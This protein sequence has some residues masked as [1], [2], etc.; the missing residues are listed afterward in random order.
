MVCGEDTMA[1]KKI[2]MLANLPRA[3]EVMD[4]YR[5]DGLL[6]ATQINVYYLTNFWG[7]LMR[8]RRMFFNYAVLPRDPKKPAA[9]VMTTAETSRLS[10]MPTWVPNVV[11]Y[12][13][14]SHAAMRNYDPVAEEPGAGVALQW[15]VRKAHLSAKEKRW[16]TMSRPLAA[17][18]KATPIYALKSALT[19]AGLVKG[20]LAFDDPRPVEWVNAVGL[21]LDGVEGT[22]IFREIRMIKS[23]DEIKLLR[24]AARINE[25]GVDAAIRAMHLGSTWPE[26]E[27][28]YNIA[29]AKE[30]GRGVYLTTGGLGL[31]HDKVIK[32]EPV[33]FDALAEFKHYHGDIGRTAIIGK[34]SAEIVRRN[35]AMTAGWETAYGMIRPGVT[36]R[37]M[38][39]KVI[40]AIEREGFPGFMIATPHSI[41]LEHT[42]H[43]LPIGLDLPGSKGDFVFRENMVI[44]VD[45][46]YHEYGFGGMHLEDMVVVTKDG[47][48]PLTSMRTDLVVIKG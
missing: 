9:L 14:P 37:Q 7:A 39:D 47:C 42:D 46:P 4:K 35:N 2:P 12:S 26:L 32:G 19:D 24:E 23:K 33:M 22:N 5:L 36:G 48:E 31:P 25:A 41:G 11:S 44:N 6:A 17:R 21:E 10:D 16:L 3:Y 29:V 45:L 38:H 15:P 43:P 1:A 18:T 20:R 30:G 28:A 40:K 27:R 8:M 13:H 34:P